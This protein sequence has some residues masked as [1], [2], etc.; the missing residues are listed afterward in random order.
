M[1]TRDTVGAPVVA[2]EG[3]DD[4]A[5]V[6]AADVVVA[7]HRSRRRARRWIHRVRRR[8]PGCTVA[9]GWQRAGRWCVLGV[10]GLVVVAAG[11]GLPRSAD[12]VAAFGRAVFAAWL[13]CHAGRRGGGS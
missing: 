11:A 5:W 12:D 2:V 6:Q 1:S 3:Q 7:P 13:Y 4:P 9:V 10:P 8:Y